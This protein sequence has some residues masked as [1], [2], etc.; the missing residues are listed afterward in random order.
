MNDDTLKAAR[1]FFTRD[2][3]ATGYATNWRLSENKAVELMADFCDSRTA[4]LR[5]RLEVARVALEH[6]ADESFWDSLT[7]AEAAG[8][9]DETLYNYEGEFDGKVPGHFVASEALKEMGV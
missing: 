3:Y 6:Y 5:R 8:Y 9:G 1:E 2:K 4:E 7:E